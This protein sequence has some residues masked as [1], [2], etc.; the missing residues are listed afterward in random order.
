LASANEMCQSMSACS[1]SVGDSASWLRAVPTAS[2]CSLIET[3]IAASSASLEG[4]CR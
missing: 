3:S 1:A 2:S 4:K